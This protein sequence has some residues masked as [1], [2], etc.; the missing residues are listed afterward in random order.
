MY[1]HIIDLLYNILMAIIQCNGFP[2]SRVPFNILGI[3]LQAFGSM[4]RKGSTDFTKLQKVEVPL[5]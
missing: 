5:G 4:L 1:Y 3:L 2:G